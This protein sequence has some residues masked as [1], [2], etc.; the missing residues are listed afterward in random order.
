MIQTALTTGGAVVAAQYIGQKN[1]KKACSAANQLLLASVLAAGI[2]MGISLIWH[3][4]ILRII[5]GKIET[6]VMNS[7]NTYF[8]IMSFS[9]PFLAASSLVSRSEN[10]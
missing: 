9:L 5:F 7:A 1:Q 6:D 8:V 4:A 2:L 3:D 10:Y